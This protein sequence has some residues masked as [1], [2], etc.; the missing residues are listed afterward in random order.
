[1]ARPMRSEFPGSLYQVMSRGSQRRDIVRDESDP[2]NSVKG[3]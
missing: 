1:M 3:K 2:K